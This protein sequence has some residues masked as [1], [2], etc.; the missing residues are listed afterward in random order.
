M[1]RATILLVLL[2]VITSCYSVPVETE[3]GF[4]SI[5]RHD[6]LS[7]NSNAID[8]TYVSRNPYVVKIDEKGDIIG[9]HV[10]ETVVEIK[11][12]NGECAVAVEVCPRH[13]YLYD[14]VLSWRASKKQII[15]KCGSPDTETSESLT[16][17]YGDMFYDDI[18]IGT[19]Y[20]FEYGGLDNVV[21]V[22]NPDYVYEV[23]QHLEE[24]FEYVGE[25]AGVL[26]YCDSLDYDNYKSL[27]VLTKQKG[28]YIILYVDASNSK[29]SDNISDILD[30]ISF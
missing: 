9:N 21:V 16:Y 14:P 17:V 8:P 19:S 15:E 3:S 23:R 26:T 10:G 2:S 30:N 18:H 13:D 24:R 12:K 28:M 7:I 5:K 29:A 6:R 22:I 25:I 27:I 20:N 1:K 4:Y 11:A